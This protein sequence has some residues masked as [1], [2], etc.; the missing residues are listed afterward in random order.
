MFWKW[1]LLYA[2][3]VMNV[4]FNH[5]HLLQRK[6]YQKN[7]ATYEVI[8]NTILAENPNHYYKAHVRGMLTKLVNN[9]EIVETS[10]DS[11]VTMYK[12][13]HA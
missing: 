9:N 8:A 13:G 2:I 10:G 3:F 7:G 11:G 5:I 6:T 12:M 1:V 4:L